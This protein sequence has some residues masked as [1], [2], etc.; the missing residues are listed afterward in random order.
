MQAR[1]SISVLHPLTLDRLEAALAGPGCPICWEAERSR[2][3][4]LRSLL[5]EHKGSEGV[6]ASL[7]RNWGLCLPHTRG[8]LAEE[9]RTVRGFSAATLYCWLTDALLE[10]AARDGSRR[11]WRSR[12][13]FRDLV[14]P[15]GGCLACRQLGAYERAAIG[16]LVGTLA[17]GEPPSVMT[18]YVGGPGLCLPHLR[19]AL[20]LTDH[21]GTA[22]LLREQV[23]KRLR[24]LSDELEVFLAAHTPGGPDQGRADF[25]VWLRAAEQFAGLI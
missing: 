3:H 2:R 13:R 10:E 16:G 9:T 4:Y 18:A 11:R 21:P 5:R 15:R 24:A 19:V 20:D 17:S 6:W 14:E 12:S 25:D 22:D 1:K 7:R 23:L 8:L